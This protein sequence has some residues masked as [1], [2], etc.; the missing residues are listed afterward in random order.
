MP[1]PKPEAAP[2][3]MAKAE[4]KAEPK[5][6]AKPQ[7]DGVCED[8]DQG[9]A[10]WKASG[11]CETHKDL[12]SYYCPASCGTCSGGPGPAAD[13]RD[14]SILYICFSNYS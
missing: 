8:I 7:I 1:E 11:F 3:A 10:G 9:C 5:A 12:M 4:P 2:L 14:S 6:E 13:V